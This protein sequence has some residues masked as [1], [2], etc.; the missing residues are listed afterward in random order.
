MASIMAKMM[1][2]YDLELVNK[3][4]DFEAASHCHVKWWKAPV[5]V[6]FVER[7]DAGA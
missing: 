7:K 2:T 3:E 1:F 5:W 4:L 6:R